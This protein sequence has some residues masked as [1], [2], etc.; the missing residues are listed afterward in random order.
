VSDSRPSAR[1]Y[2]PAL[3][4]VR[5]VAI[6]AVVTYHL[7]HLGGGWLGVDVFFVLSGYLITTLLLSELASRGRVGLRRFWARRARRLLPAVLL[8]LF[9]LGVYAWVGGP[10]LTPAQL[11]SPALATLFYVANWQQIAFSHNYFASFTA[12]TP[13]LHTWSLAIE[14]Q[15]YLCWPLLVVAV[16]ALTRRWRSRHRDAVRPAFASGA[17]R[18]LVAVTALLLVASAV[19]M[20][21]TAHLVSVNRAYLGTDTRAWELL[22]G[23]LAASLV[24]PVPS[25]RRQRW[26]GAGTVVAAAGLAAAIAL[27]KTS[28][29]SALPPMWVWDGG[30]VA[31]GCCVTALITGSVRAPQ[32][33]LARV[34][35]LGPV[36]WLGRVSYSLYLWHWPV[37]DLVTPTTIGLAGWQLLAVRL[38]LMAGATCTS[39]YLVERPLRRA[40]WSRWWRRA[41]VPLAIGATGAVLLAATVTPPPAQTAQL[42]GAAKGRATESS[43]AGPITPSSIGR[44]GLAPTKTDPLRVWILGDSVMFDSSPGITA[45]LQATGRATVVTNSSFGGWGLTTATSWPEASQQIIEQYHPQMVLGTWSWDDTEASLDPKAYETLLH[46]ALATWL[47]P[48]NGIKLVVLLQFPQRG[49]SPPSEIDPLATTLKAWALETRQQDAWNAIAKRVVLDFPGHA[50]YLST[51]QLFA[52][53]GRFLTWFRTPQGTWVR[54][55]KLDQTHMCPYGAA[56]FGLLIVNDLNRSLHLGQPFSG[57]QYRAWTAN[58]TFNDPPGACPNDQPPAHY[59][60]ELVPGTPRAHRG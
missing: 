54:A 44:I 28:G 58:P 5:A 21:V 40:D 30:L 33:P 22:L 32:G 29:A 45:A 1:Q 10:G 41:I 9:V 49:P 59:R 16:T 38:G 43:A 6:V 35:S 8:L 42:A 55:R 53:D 37:I 23:G 51:N 12:P 46:Q 18:A 4:G 20:G 39:Y 52:P 27:S 7:G 31:T 34:L 19:G 36:R 25:A 56:E 48:G 13:L 50:E 14:E 57:W 3:D 15:Y 24:P 26:W 60:G 47:A 17:P 11:R 2:W